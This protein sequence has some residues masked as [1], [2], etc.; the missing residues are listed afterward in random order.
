MAYNYTA[1][2]EFRVQHAGCKKASH[3]Q[4]SPSLQ[5]H[6]PVSKSEATVL[7]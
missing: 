3:K 2:S 4:E 7:P 5:E 6:N 1:F